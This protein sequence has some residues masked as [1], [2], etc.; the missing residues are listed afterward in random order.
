M[1]NIPQVAKDN[2]GN[3]LTVL[4]IL[5]MSLGF[6]SVVVTKPEVAA[7][8]AQIAEVNTNISML[9]MELTIRVNENKLHSLD[10]LITRTPEQDREI[11]ALEASNIRLTG[12]M[13]DTLND[14]N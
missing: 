6:L 14:A 12:K 3:I 10:K 13:E 7:V 5:S 4:T 2:L 9:R 11:T 1:P 8:K